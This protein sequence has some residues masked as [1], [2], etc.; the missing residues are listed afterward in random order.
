MD[1]R[2]VTFS[3]SNMVHIYEPK[4]GYIPRDPYYSHKDIESALKFLKDM[5]KTDIEIKTYRSKNN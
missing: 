4:C 3:C 2:I 1:N 5:G